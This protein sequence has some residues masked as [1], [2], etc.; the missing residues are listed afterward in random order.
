[1]K[2]DLQ[3]LLSFNHSILNG[4]IGVYFLDVSLLMYSERV[5]RKNLPSW[6]SVVLITPSSARLDGLCQL[7]FYNGTSTWQQQ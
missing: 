2:L 3:Y 4:S 7:P 5:V 6:I 1:M